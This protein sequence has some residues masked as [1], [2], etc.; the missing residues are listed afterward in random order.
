MSTYWFMKRTSTKIVAISKEWTSFANDERFDMNSCSL[1]LI[2][3]DSLHQKFEKVR[4]DDHDQ[5]QFEHD[6]I[7]NRYSNSRRADRHMIEMRFT[8]IKNSRKYDETNHDFHNVVDLHL[9]ND[10]SQNQNVVHLRCSFDFHLRRFL[11]T[12]AQE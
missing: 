5:N 11:L 10:F 1:R 3:V 9:N 4:H 12:H 6:L 8:R 7:E 2:R